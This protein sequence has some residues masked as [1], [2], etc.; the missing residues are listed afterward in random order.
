MPEENANTPAQNQNNG[1]GLLRQIQNGIKKDQMDQLRK[2][3]KPLVAEIN[4]AQKTIKVKTAQIVA[5]LEDAGLDPS[6]VGNLF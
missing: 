6:E 2:D 4:A 1:G 3:V 5:M